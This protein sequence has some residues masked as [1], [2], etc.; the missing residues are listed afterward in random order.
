MYPTRI[1]RSALPQL[2]DEKPNITGFSMKKFLANTKKPRYDPWERNEAWRYTGRFSRFN[3]YRNAL[4]G[5]GT[6]VVAF[7]AYCVYE[8]LF[9][10]KDERH[11][12]EEHH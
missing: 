4:P 9:L 5:F 7:T 1:L 2:G 10:K 6:A 11:H 3:R 12:G 8:Q